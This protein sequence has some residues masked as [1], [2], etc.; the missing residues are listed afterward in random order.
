MCDGFGQNRPRSRCA[1][2]SDLATTDRAH[3]AVRYRRDP[4]I[5]EPGAAAGALELIVGS[6]HT[7][8]MV[9]KSNIRRSKVIRCS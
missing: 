7:V 1:P 6:G 5:V 2:V 4:L 9:H 8:I 3:L